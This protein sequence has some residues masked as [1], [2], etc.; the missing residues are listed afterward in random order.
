MSLKQGYQPSMKNRADESFNRQH[1]RLKMAKKYSTLLSALQAQYF[2][3]FF[4]N[5]CGL[6]R[7]N[8]DFDVIL[9]VYS[10]FRLE[11]DERGC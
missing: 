7:I 11:Q 3:N 5:Q 4:K 2:S 1:G 6:L 10:R 8:Y 9:F